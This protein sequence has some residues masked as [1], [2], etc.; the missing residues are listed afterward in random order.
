LIASID[1]FRV[2]NDMVANIPQAQQQTA[3]GQGKS[4]ALG[5]AYFGLFVTRILWLLGVIGILI[6]LLIER[7]KKPGQSTPATACMTVRERVALFVF[8]IVP[9]PA[10]HFGTE[11]LYTLVMQFDTV[12]TVPAAQRDAVIVQSQSIFHSSLYLGVI[13]TGV[14]LLGA[15]YWRYVTKPKVMP[16]VK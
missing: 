8:S 10:I 6:A 7:N 16:S 4:I 3:L 15:L 1:M 12:A 11:I 14:C 13:L 5:M 2:V 9:I